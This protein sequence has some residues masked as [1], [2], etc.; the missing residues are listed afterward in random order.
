MRT[1]D[2]IARFYGTREV[3]EAVLDFVRGDVLDFGSG[4]GK[5]KP[6]LSTKAK[7]YMALDMSPHPSVDIVGDILDPPIGDGS[8]AMDILCLLNASD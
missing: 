1:A 5:H 4:K 7:A 8:Y 3:M 2:H 6:L